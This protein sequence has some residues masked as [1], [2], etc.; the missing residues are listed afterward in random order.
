MLASAIPL[1]ICWWL[2]P[3]PPEIASLRATRDALSSNIT[4]LRQQGGALQLKRCGPQQRLCAR[5]DRTAPSYGV[6]A[7]YL[8]LKGY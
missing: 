2:L 8:V 1:S 7:D 5:V 3:Q 6:A 4:Y